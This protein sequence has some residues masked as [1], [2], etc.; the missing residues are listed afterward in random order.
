MIS[1][2]N[3]TEER[4]KESRAAP[5]CHLE[6]SNEQKHAEEIKQEKNKRDHG[7][8]VCSLHQKEAALDQYKWNAFIPEKSLVSKKGAL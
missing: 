1:K 3:P 5:F 2:G 7:Y 4:H 6:S 8:S